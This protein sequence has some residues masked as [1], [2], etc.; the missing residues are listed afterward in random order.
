MSDTFGPVSVGTSSGK[1]KTNDLGIC[2][3]WLIKIVIVDPQQ[4][5]FIFMGRIYKI[6]NKFNTKK[7]SLN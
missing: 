2:V 3:S 7:G 5:N 1:E 6:N 4:W